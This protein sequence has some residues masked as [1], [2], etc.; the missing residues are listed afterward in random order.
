MI[1]LIHMAAEKVAQLAG[2][3]ADEALNIGLAVRE[4]AINAVWYQRNHGQGG[5]L[6]LGWS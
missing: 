3:D 6:S 2:F 5:P 1:D 4:G